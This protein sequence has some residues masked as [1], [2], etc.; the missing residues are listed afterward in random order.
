MELNDVLWKV[1]AER[2][3]LV[4]G[5]ALGLL[6][7]AV[8][9][10]SAVRT[11]TSSTQLFVSVTRTT[12]T[13]SAYEGN[14]FSQQRI[15]SYA[16]ILTGT[17][18]AQQVVDELGLPLSAQAVAAKVSVT[19]V[20]E[21]VVLDV[22]VLDTSPERAQAIAASVGRQYTQAARVLETPEGSTTP[23]VAVST[24]QDADFNPTPVS[25][26]VFGNLWRGAAVG[27]VLALAVV[28]VRARLDRSVRNDDDVRD[29]TGTEV[30][31]RV[32][33]DRHAFKRGALRTS[34]ISSTT[35][36]SYRAVG[37]FLRYA[38]LEHR[39]QVVTLTSA[40]AGEGKSTVAVNLALSLARSGSRVVLVDA[41]LARPRTARYLG[42]AEGVGLV[43]VLTG[44]VP[45]G[46]AVQQWQDSTLAVLPAGPMPRNPSEL[47]GSG[48]MRAV[49][50]SL[51]GTYDFVLVDAPPV[52]PVADGAVLA[53]LADGCLLVTRFGKT[54]REQVADTASAIQRISGRV[55]GVVVNRVPG[56]AVPTA[57][58]QKYRP[59]PDRK[60]VD[61]RPARIEPPGD[62][63]HDQAPQPA[64]VVDDGAQEQS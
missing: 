3:I 23:T 59:D 45:L 56:V 52:L 4:V 51:R 22:R 39:P 25:P 14:L 63:V 64:R 57:N 54:R 50:K 1:R 36:E 35:A 20:P 29:V 58:R 11:Y 2:R 32:H 7:A 44:A 27:L 6:A 43:D 40:L 28:V 30:V 46:E 5:V 62:V 33:E 15:A 53:A 16:E 26:D 10:W 17:Q 61:R 47:L 12:D 48:Q 49:L 37:A 8:L 41:N 21:T 18:L 13:A 9:N 34:D 19:P 42:V 24:I 38:N 60:P 31:G 55:L